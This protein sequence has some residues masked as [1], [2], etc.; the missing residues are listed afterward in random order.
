MINVLLL[1]I[2]KYLPNLLFSADR[3]Q[4]FLTWINHFPL[5]TLVLFTLGRKIF[6]EVVK[7]I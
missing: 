5:F 2:H 3:L 4:K 1:L 6:Y 7:E